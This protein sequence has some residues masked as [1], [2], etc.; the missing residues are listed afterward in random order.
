[1]ARSTSSQGGDRVIV[2][3]KTDGY[4][5]A[6]VVCVTE[7]EVP[8]RHILGVEALPKRGADPALF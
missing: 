1:M 4:S 2:T 6:R 8:D 5:A 7:Q 3:R